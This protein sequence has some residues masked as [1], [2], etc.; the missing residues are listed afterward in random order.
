MLGL[1]RCCARTSILWYSSGT[2][3]HVE[4][5]CCFK[6]A[7]ALGPSVHKYVENGKRWRQLCGFDR[8]VDQLGAI[9]LMVEWPAQVLSTPHHL[10]HRLHLMWAATSGT[11]SQHV[12]ISQH[13]QTPR[14]CRA[15]ADRKN[16]KSMLPL[17]SNPPPWKPRS[18]ILPVSPC[19]NQEACPLHVCQRSAWRSRARRLLQDQPKGATC[20][21]G[22]TSVPAVI[23]M[24]PLRESGKLPIDLGTWP[25]QED[26]RLLGGSGSVA[27]MMHQT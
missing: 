12:A 4:W 6:V 2:A 16:P 13:Q 18:L 9:A 5:L 23:L 19:I 21:E 17:A 24:L 8:G 3:V 20:R 26:K 15:A 10:P 7:A 11:H 22:D 14:C 27:I 25:K 1:S